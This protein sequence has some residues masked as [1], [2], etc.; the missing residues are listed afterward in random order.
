MRET[1]FL[2]INNN[3]NK[4]TNNTEKLLGVN[5]LE[6]TSQALYGKKIEAN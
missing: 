4:L 1:C 5:D 6:C 3:N 2:Y